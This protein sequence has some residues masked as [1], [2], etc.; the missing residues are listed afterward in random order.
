[1]FGYIKPYLPYLYG[2]DDTLYKSL[3]C[4]I[5]KSIGKNCGQLS[6]MG[7]TYDIAFL[8]A[9]AHNVMGVDVKIEKSHC[10]L[11]PIISRPIAKID[12][13]S[14][15]LADINTIMVYYKLQDD[16]ADEKKG[17]LKSLFFKKGFKKS[18][19]RNPQI[20]NIIKDYCQRL[21]KEEK[22]LNDS[23]DMVCDFSASLL[24]EISNEVLGEFAT[25][26]TANFFYFI[27]KWVYLIDALD[28]YDKDVK[29]GSYNVFYQAYKEKTFSDLVKNHSKDLGFVFNDVFSKLNENFKN[30]KFKFNKDLIENIVFRGLPKQTTK[31][32]QKSQNKKGSKKRSKKDDLLGENYE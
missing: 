32:L 11:H 13:I 4:G 8:S 22:S 15:K 5:C 14:L 9:V 7:L 29:N 12:E 27:G 24:M 16:I 31:V 21:S 23:I 17:T 25:E 18:F 26:S 6:R 30:I 1:M 2:K 28:D 19:K 10:V 20:A 3:Y